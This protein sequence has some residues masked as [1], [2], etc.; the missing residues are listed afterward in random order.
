LL[1]SIEIGPFTV[2]TYG[3]MMS[4]GFILILLGAR[5]MA[6]SIGISSDK[7]MDLAL[8]AILGG[9]IGSY[10]NYVISYDWARVAA[11]PIRIFFFWEGG[12]VFLGG[13]LG[14]IA[15]ALLYI[16]WQK[17]PLWEIA[18][19][20]AVFVP[21]GYAIGRIGCFMA[22]CC[23]GISTSLP[24]GCEFPG[25]VGPVHPTQLYS[26]LLGFSLVAFALLFRKHRSFAGQSFLL[27]VFIYGIG[28]S[29]IELLRMNPTVIG[30]LTVAQV[31]GLVMTAVAAGLYPVL[32][33]Y[34]RLEEDSQAGNGS[35]EIE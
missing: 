19:L 33:R 22:G 35:D 29:L 27:Y 25:T 31:T 7:A 8:F 14:G 16:W 6:P 30:G 26:S 1:P 11:D 32:R 12:L 15:F 13:L 21:L 23:H 2:Y 17:M 18:D 4:L 10:I 24:W 34:N 28:R 20:A 3:L 9:L 5:K